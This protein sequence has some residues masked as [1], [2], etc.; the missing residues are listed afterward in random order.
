MPF[1]RNCEFSTFDE[2]VAQQVEE[3][4]S[5][6]AAKRICGALQAETEED[7]AADARAAVYETGGQCNHDPDA[8][9]INCRE[10]CARCNDWREGGHDPH[11]DLL[12]GVLP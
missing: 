6:S 12:H 2:C 1:G 9:C 3:G 11:D 4:K 8:W 10:F 5:E 7:C